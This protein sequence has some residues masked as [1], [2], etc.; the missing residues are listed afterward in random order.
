[1]AGKPWLNFYPLAQVIFY[2][3]Y[4]TYGAV[5]ISILKLAV[6]LSTFALLYKTPRPTPKPMLSAVHTFAVLIIGFSP[7][8]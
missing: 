8:S 4:N 2:W 6:E 3:V 5:G 7:I 1:M